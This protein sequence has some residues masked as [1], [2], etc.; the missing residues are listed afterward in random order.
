MTVWTLLPLQFC[1]PSSAITVFV[2]VIVTNNNKTK[3]VKISLFHRGRGHHIVKFTHWFCK[4]IM[5]LK[6]RRKIIPFKQV[7]SAQLNRFIS[8]RF[9]DWK[10]VTENRPINSVWAAFIEIN[11][12]TTEL[13]C[14]AVPQCFSRRMPFIRHVVGAPSERER[15]K[16]RKKDNLSAGYGYHLCLLLKSR[17]VSY[18]RACTHIHNT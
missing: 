11:S 1:C 10:S 9:Y 17:R 6:N 2:V 13:C 15:K 16:E 5:C 14:A 12:R 3:C 18:S 8:V 4:K 7:R